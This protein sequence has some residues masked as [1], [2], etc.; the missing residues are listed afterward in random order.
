MIILPL[1]LW[2]N[3]KDKIIGLKEVGANLLNFQIIWSVL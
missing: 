2:M 1:I 3:K